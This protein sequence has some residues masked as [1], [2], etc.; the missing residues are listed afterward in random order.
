M[1]ETM[2]IQEPP[3]SQGPPQIPHNY[4]KPQTPVVIQNLIPHDGF[5]NDQHAPIN[6]S[7]E[8]PCTS[9]SFVTPHMGNPPHT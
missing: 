4:L 9:T 7:S 5:I 3:A 6:P 1:K 8:V 2:N